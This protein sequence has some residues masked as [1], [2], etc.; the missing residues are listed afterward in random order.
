MAW[1]C[2]SVKRATITTYLGGAELQ[3]PQS[4]QGQLRKGNTEVGNLAG[5]AR[6]ACYAVNISKSEG[7]KG[8]LP[9]PLFLFWILKP[10]SES[11]SQR[12]LGSD[13]RTLKLASCHLAVILVWHSVS[14]VDSV[15]VV[16]LAGNVPQKNM[17]QKLFDT[18]R[19]Y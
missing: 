17:I 13:Q 19:S 10:M 6:L 7:W 14:C 15:P 1:V 18:K 2:G 16:F 9:T 3:N 12:H 5:E 11:E 4:K 8:L